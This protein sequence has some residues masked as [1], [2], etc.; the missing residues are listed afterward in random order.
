MVIGASAVRLRNHQI[1][2]SLTIRNVFDVAYRDYLSRYR[3]YVNEPGRDVVLRFTMPFGSA[4]PV[5]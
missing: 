2:P 1:E 5:R 4:S 3:L